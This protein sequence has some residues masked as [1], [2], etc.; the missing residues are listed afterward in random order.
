MTDRRGL[1]RRVPRSRRI[2]DS[3]RRKSAC[4]RAGEVQAQ[5]RGVPMRQF[6]DLKNPKMN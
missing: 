2:A 3:R 5:P 1:L 6:L 4:A